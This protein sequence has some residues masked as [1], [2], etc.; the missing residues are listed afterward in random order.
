VR[1]SLGPVVAPVLLVEHCPVCGASGGE[2]LGY[3]LERCA[4]CGAVYATR[5]A[6]PDA[7]Y[8]DGYYTAGGEFGLD[9]LHPRFQR[10]LELAARRRV[11]RIERLAGRRGTWLDV[12]CGTGEL[13][14]GARDA[15]WTTVGVEPTEDSARIARDRG[16][17]V[18]VAMLD[19][20]GVEPGA[21]D[22]VTAFHVLEHVPDVVALVRDLGRWARPGGLVVA[23]CPNWDARLRESTGLGGW[24]DLRPLE[25]VTHFTPGTL[26]AALRAAGLEPVAVG[27]DSYPSPEHTLEE[28]C[29]SAGRPGLA[30]RLRP[31]CRERDAGGVR[32]TAPGPALRR[33][34]RAL[35]AADERRGRGR[36]VWA[37]ARVPG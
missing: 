5:R 9:V 13:L 31:L 2:P 33:A 27:T 35:A 34:I 17:D 29:E 14:A 7:V 23:E 4:G 37:A 28:A 30:R 8:T 6:D 36:T 16:L 26:P 15:G 10:F 1:T 20:S 22:V 12:G 24:P 19:R 18:R 25:H 21:W 32:A 3:D 11:A